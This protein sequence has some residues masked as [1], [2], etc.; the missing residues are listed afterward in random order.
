MR[1]TTHPS[2]Y[3]GPPPR[4]RG[5]NRPRRP[6][7][8]A[9]WERE[10]EDRLRQEPISYW[11]LTRRPLP[12]L[13]FVL[14]LLL[15]YEL[16]V[17]LL[18]RPD[19]ATLRTGVDAWLHQALA[20]FGLREPWVPAAGLV[21]GLMAWQV[22]DRRPGRFRFTCLP[23]MVFESL[24]LAVVLVGLGRLVDLGLTNL[25]QA[26][27]LPLP[28]NASATGSGSPHPLAP[29]V[30]YLGAGIYEE[31]LFRLALLPLRYG[32]L[33]LLLTP[34]LLAGTLAVTGSA[35]LFSIAHHAGVPGEV[36]TW[37][38]FF[39]RWAAGIFFAW[40]FIVRGFGVAVGTHA[41]YDILVGWIG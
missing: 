24:I 39:F 21:G 28:L 2:Q 9:Y 10:S 1:P 16:G 14:P 32:V 6:S 22:F 4:G 35:L 5:R 23:G 8:L 19:S 37:Y 33:R 15:A 41:A 34:S 18:T 7:D 29:V 3:P 20:A 25:D 11:A 17:K 40:V 31:A 26:R 38:A 36:F 30:G 12:S 13:L 27:S